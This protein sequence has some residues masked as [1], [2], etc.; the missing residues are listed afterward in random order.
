MRLYEWKRVW[1]CM[2]TERTS[3][4]K[5][6]AISGE[7]EFKQN[8]YYENQKD[9]KSEQDSGSRGQISLEASSHT[10]FYWRPNSAISTL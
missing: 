2:R 8:N 3:E 1:D 6:L 10:F 5:S 7:R 4:W 9:E